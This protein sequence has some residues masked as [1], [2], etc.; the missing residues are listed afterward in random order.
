[1][2]LTTHRGKMYDDPVIFALRDKASQIVGLL[3]AVDVILAI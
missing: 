2:W 1:M 3:A